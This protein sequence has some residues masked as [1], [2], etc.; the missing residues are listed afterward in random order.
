MNA[1]SRAIHD[2]AAPTRVADLMDLMYD[3]VESKE[4]DQSDRPDKFSFSTLC[5]QSMRKCKFCDWL[6]HFQPNWSD[7]HWLSSFT[8]IFR[9]VSV[10]VEVGLAIISTTLHVTVE[11]VIKNHKSARAA[12]CMERWQS[13]PLERDVW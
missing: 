1:W 5:W 2:A 6:Q 9:I 3:M 10:F 13:S 11:T 4:L 7:K 8:S 12:H